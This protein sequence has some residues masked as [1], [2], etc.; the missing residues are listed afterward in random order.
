MSEQNSNFLPEKV[1]EIMVQQV[2]KR[3]KVNPE[4]VKKNISEDQKQMLREM[5]QDLKKQVEEFNKG[6]KNKTKTSDE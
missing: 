6:N 3:N 4:E 2:L 5:V 1:V